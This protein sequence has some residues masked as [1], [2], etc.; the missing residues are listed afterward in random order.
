[1][2]SKYASYIYE[3][4]G[5][6]MLETEHGF[7]T[8]WFPNNDVCY[9]EDLFVLPDHRK[10]NVATDLANQICEIAKSKGCKRLLGSINLNTKNPTRNM[11]VFLAYGMQLTSCDNN[12]IYLT[13]DL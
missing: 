8:Y 13:K 3:R 2:I 10:S 1:M 5:K 9:L 12:M 7:A 6:S 11:K 4:E